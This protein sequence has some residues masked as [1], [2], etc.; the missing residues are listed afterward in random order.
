MPRALILF[1]IAASLALMVAAATPLGFLAAQLAPPDLFLARDPA[2][3]GTLAAALSVALV[4]SLISLGLGGTVALGL[5][6]ASA[7]VRTLVLALCAAAELLAALH[8]EASSF[9]PAPD[10]PLIAALPGL[11]VLAT[12]LVI[13]ILAARLRSLDPVLLGTAAASGASP[14]RAFTSVVLSWLA[15][16]ALAAFLVCFVATAGDT[17]IG[18]AR[19]NPLN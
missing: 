16:P 8:A 19:H 7:A 1:A 6:Q 14:S 11:V 18:L 9:F 15:G 13:L 2:V 3:T 4:A 17:L 12:P 5:W 10:R